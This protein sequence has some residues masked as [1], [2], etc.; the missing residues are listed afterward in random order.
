MRN[1]SH[2][3]ILAVAA[4]AAIMLLD[5][6][7]VRAEPEPEQVVREIYLSF[8]NRAN[9]DAPSVEWLSARER[10]TAHFSRRMVEFFNANDT[11][12]DDLALACY[13]FSLEFNG[14]DFAE[15]EILE[16]LATKADDDAGR[17][18][19]EASFT[20]FG[21]PNRFRYEF[22]REDGAWK[23]D[24]I[25]SLETAVWRVSDIPCAP[26]AG[27][28]LRG[29]ETIR[30]VQRRLSEMGFD[31]GEVDGRFGGRTAAAISAFERSRGLPETRAMNAQTVA[32]LASYNAP[33]ALVVAKTAAEGMSP[34]DHC[35]ARRNSTLKLTVRGNGETWF[36]LDSVQGGG[37][38]CGLEGVAQPAAGGWQYAE[39][40]S[41][42]TCRLDILN[43]GGGIG[44]RDAGGLCRE[45]YCGAR[46][47]LDSIT[48]AAS[49][50]GPC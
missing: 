42:G 9:P 15:K 11:F 19:V 39:K 16:T 31:P 44:F 33:V 40:V 3:W 35:F 13:D 26:A 36:G 50:E 41:G 2:R 1:N 14:Q 21:E 28:A 8:A 38:M 5:V 7:H 18:I 37:H 48:F 46:A 30:F 47:D 43:S 27:A 23:I 17:R 24:D 20:N 45:T 4:A 49:D 10:R 34:G 22:V 29:S 12:G 32:A 25:V 6:G